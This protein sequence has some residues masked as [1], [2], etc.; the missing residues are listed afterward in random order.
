MVKISSRANC[1]AR[2]GPTPHNVFTGR[3]MGEAWGLADTA[4][5]S[6]AISKAAGL[7]R[8]RD[9]LVVRPQGVFAKVVLE[10]APD[11]VDVIGVVLGIV[12]LHQKSRALNAIIMA[13]AGFQSARP[14][15]MKVIVAGL[16][17]FAEIRFGD[18]VAVAEHEFFEQRREQFL[19]RLSQRGGGDTQRFQ[20]P[21]FAGVA[22]D[23]VTRS[24]GGKDGG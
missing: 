5:I 20:R 19:L 17:D 8:V 9:L 18:F 22:G 15:E 11:G 16:A 3:A 6:S 4:V 23:D 21:G 24:V 7:L 12:V 1:A 2:S 10:I 13:L 14:G